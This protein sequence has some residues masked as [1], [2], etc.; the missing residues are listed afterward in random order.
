LTYTYTND[1]GELFR[2]EIISGHINHGQEVM[3]TSSYYR[4]SINTGNNHL[5]IN[6]IHEQFDFLRR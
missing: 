6:S 3:K 1:N 5:V 2:A 4:Y